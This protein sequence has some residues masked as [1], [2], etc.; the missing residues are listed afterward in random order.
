MRLLALSLDL[1][2]N[3]FDPIF[4]HPMTF[5]RPLRYAPV[6]SSPAEGIFGAGAHSDYGLLTFLATDDVPGLEIYLNGKWVEAPPKRGAFVVNLGDMFQRWSNG[7][8]RST[9]HR[10]INKLGKERFSIPFFFEPNFHAKLD[11]LV[12]ESGPYK[13]ADPEEDTIGTAGEYI[14]YKYR[15]THAGYIEKKS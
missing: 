6:K 12:K 15:S 4:T 3:S 10:V 7:K 9:V 2:A 14:L 11:P 8:F 13:S 5:L 1:P